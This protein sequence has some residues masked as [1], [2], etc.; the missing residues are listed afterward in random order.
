MMNDNKNNMKQFQTRI[1]KKF[2]SK[3]SLKFE[4]EAKRMKKSL[5]KQK[6]K[7]SLKRLTRNIGL[8]CQLNGNKMML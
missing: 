8:D 1:E 4:I 6:K 5:S 2:N 3:K 7:K